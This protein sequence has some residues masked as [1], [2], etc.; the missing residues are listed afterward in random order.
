MKAHTLINE[1]AL[2]E[3]KRYLIK[4]AIKIIIW[5]TSVVLFVFAIVAAWFGD[6]VN[7]AIMA[8]G[9]ILFQVELHVLTNKHVKSALNTLRELYGKD[10]VEGEL[11]LDE[12][13]MHV[14]NPLTNADL[15]LSYAVMSR[16]IGTRHYYL[17]ITAQ[18]QWVLIDKGQFTEEL[19][20]QFIQMINEKMP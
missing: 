12:K 20:R 11:I 5:T 8:I 15:A 13:E 14:I 19:H 18:W 4:P 16:L 7:A 9:I 3:I 6:Y 2:N 10:M 17:L 1:A